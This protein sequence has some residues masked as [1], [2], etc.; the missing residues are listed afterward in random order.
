MSQR[1]ASNHVRLGLFVLVGLGILLVTLFLLGR[2]QN[3]FSRS[4][5]VQADFRNVSGLLTGNNVRLGGIPVG[6]VRKI[7]ILNDTTVRVVMNLNRDAQPFV[8]KNAVAAIGTDGLVGNTIINLSA[9]P[10][11]APA[12]Q[13]GDVLRT[14]SPVG[15]DD[16]LSTLAVSNKNLV[17]ITRNM[18]SITEKLNTS[19]ALWGLLSDE[20][21]AANLRQSVRNTAAATA[22][23]QGT[24][25]HLHA[26]AHDVKVLTR[27]AR[28]GRGPLGYLFTD[29]AFAGQLG[30]AARQLAGTSDTMATML[31]GLKTQVRTGEGPMSTLLTDTTFSRQM[32]QS[33]GHVA[34]G[35]Q[36]FSQTMQALQ[37]NFLFRGYFR[38]Q[39]KR[40]ARAAAQPEAN[41]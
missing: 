38:R 31:N 37:H 2:Q 32:R 7:Q 40:Q 23:A 28:Q 11:P 29:T 5:L 17:R 4:F 41:K 25:E 13:P 22:L 24:G 18:T 21:L 33:M 35:T 6:T 20:E 39:Q 9:R 34:Q 19:P 36:D 10:G 26:A 12:V 27:G 16:I 14:K 30:H 3:L 1:T 8:R 15:I